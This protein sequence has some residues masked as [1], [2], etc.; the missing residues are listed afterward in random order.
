MFNFLKRLNTFGK[1]G[2]EAFFILGA[3]GFVVLFFWPPLK[4]SPI[5]QGAAGNLCVY[6]PPLQSET[7]QD[8]GVAYD[9]LKKEA[10]IIGV[11]AD[12]HAKVK[13]QLT[14]K[15]KVR[16]VSRTDAVSSI[17]N[18]SI[19]DPVEQTKWHN[20]RFVD[21]SSDVLGG[22]PGTKYFDIYIKRGTTVPKD[23]ISFC[24]NNKGDWKGFLSNEQNKTFPPKEID[25]SKISPWT[26][27]GSSIPGSQA[28]CE[29]IKSR[30]GYE[31]PTSGLNYLYAYDA[32]SQEPV[33]Y[34]K[35]TNQM[36]H[37]TIT[38]EGVSYKVVYYGGWESK[39][40]RLETTDPVSGQEIGYRY[41]NPS[42][43]LIAEDPAKFLN[44]RETATDSLQ[45]KAFT[46]W[47]IPPAGWWTPE[48]KPAI[49]LY[50][51]NKMNVN[52]KVS[53]QGHLTYTDPVYDTKKGWNITAYPD[54]KLTWLDN[55]YGINSKGE[56][57]AS[58][59]YDYLYYE[60][61]IHD[62]MIKK[63]T[64]GFIIAYADL[65]SFYRNNLPKMGLNAK[66]TKDYVEYWLN[67]LPY[68]DYYFIGML[69]EKNINQIEPMIITPVPDKTLRV[70]LYYEA[71]SPENA[72][73]KTITLTKPNLENEF[74]RSGFSVVEW[75]GMVKQD[76]D[77]PFTCSM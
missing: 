66:E 20:V 37:A 68:A 64:D 42:R 73:K 7:F 25:A 12:I 11:Q 75:G 48:C 77:H 56:K 9:L 43:L 38:I 69:A 76:K 4:Y 31:A 55:A 32:N 52:V 21:V 8:E 54:S 3:I 5:K 39:H 58:N 18:W 33:A 41:A 72:A 62:S 17:S 63:P 1:I 34:V 47:Q 61:K 46:P 40:V 24:T 19:D 36:P 35:R 30:A 57:R 51:K 45:L 10:P 14:I 22:V 50:P 2:Y 65:E 16:S 44:K 60:S 27:D 67:V 26:C 13:K 29:E 6:N 28:A 23:I 53:P 15:G 74:N 70:R 71:L 49:Y 59:I